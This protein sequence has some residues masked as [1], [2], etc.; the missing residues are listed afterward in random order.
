MRIRKDTEKKL[1]KTICSVTLY[2][3]V[4]RATILLD[5]KGYPILMISQQQKD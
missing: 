2:E 3:K 1:G 4:A 5:S